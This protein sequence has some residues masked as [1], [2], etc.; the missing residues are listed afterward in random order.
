MKSLGTLLIIWEIIGRGTILTKTRKIE[1]NLRAERK[2]AFSM[3]TH[4][5]T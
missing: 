3:L 1:L 2:I 4:S 5:F